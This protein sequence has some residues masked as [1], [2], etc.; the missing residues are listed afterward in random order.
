MVAKF[1]PF[2]IA[3]TQISITLPDILDVYVR[4]QVTTG[5]Y[6][7]PSDYIEDLIQKDRDRRSQLEVMALA[8]LGSGPATPMTNENWEEIRAA[9]RQN[10]ERACS[11][12]GDRDSSDA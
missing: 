6:S 9:V 12:G 4:E 8:G 1:L 5:Q 10:L 11:A 7:S 2:T 3:M